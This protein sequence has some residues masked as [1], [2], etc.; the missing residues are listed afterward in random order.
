MAYQNLDALTFNI[1]NQS[2]TLSAAICCYLVMGRKQTT[3]QL[4]ALVILMFS[5]MIIEQVFSLDFFL[6]SHS[7]EKTR[8]VTTE[9]TR[10]FS[11]GVAP[12]LLASFLSGLAGAL[13]QRNLQD[14]GKNPYLFCMELCAASSII[15]SLSLLVTPDG[16][17]IREKGFWG[18]E[19]NY[20]VFIP[21]VTNSMGGVLV[22]LV[23]KYAGSVR[24]GFALI[25]GILISGLLQSESV[26]TEQVVGGLLAAISLWMHS[27]KSS[28]EIE[29]TLPTIQAQNDGNNEET[30]EVAE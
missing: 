10:R 30:M 6:E 24:K 2:K 29:K 3:Q 21:I 7:V 14:H 9:Q 1:L 5:G 28:T 4:M 18:D 25:F 16:Q 8:V 22:G 13:C 20:Q 23:T 19:W 12:L 11:R 27:A 15:L 17:L 26:S